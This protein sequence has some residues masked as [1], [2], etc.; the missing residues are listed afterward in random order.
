ARATADA[1]PLSLH[2][3]LPVLFRRR[4]EVDRA[5]RIHQNLLARPAM[6]R[7]QRAQALLELGQ[8]YMKA[9]LLD[10]A[11]ALFEQVIEA[12]T[13]VVPADRKSTRLNSSHVKISY[14]V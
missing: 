14:A 10:R 6:D 9:G 1:L 5:I 2:D 13:H 12:N 8:D 11:E 7:S 4:G 3:A